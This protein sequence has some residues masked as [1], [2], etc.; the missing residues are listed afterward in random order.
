MAKQQRAT[1]INVNIPKVVYDRLTHVRDELAEKTGRRVTTIET[2]E[3]AVQALED[4]HRG[5]AWLSPRE[6]APQYEARHRDALAA[7][8]MQTAA[9]CGRV[10]R[11]LA[12]NET[13]HSIEIDF[14]DDGPPV[15]FPVGALQRRNDN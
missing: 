15:T 9:A 1:R 11:G 7:A 13:T 3:R 5:N 2:L 12:F 4:A 14:A 6:A 8:I 10:V